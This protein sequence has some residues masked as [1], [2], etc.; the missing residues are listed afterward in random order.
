MPLRGIYLIVG[1]G[2]YYIGSTENYAA[3]RDR[4]IRDLNRNRHHTS[5]LQRA[6]RKHGSAAFTFLFAETV[7]GCLAR[8]EQRWIDAAIDVGSPLYNTTL[9]AGRP[10]RG[11]W[12]GRKHSP[13]ARARISAAQIGRKASDNTR[14]R[15]AAAQ[16]RRAP[17]TLETRAAISRGRTG[18][19]HTE[20]TKRKISEAKKGVP[21]APTWGRK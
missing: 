1:P 7:R 12:T 3:R 21:R 19:P 17:A 15:M 20:A 6:W 11:N 4:H 9:V 5:R 14:A 18:I 2:R 13:E 8:A 10:P 16:R